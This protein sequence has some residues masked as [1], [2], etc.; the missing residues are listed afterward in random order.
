MFKGPSTFSYHLSWNKLAL[1]ENHEFAENVSLSACAFPHEGCPALASLL[2]RPCFA[3]EAPCELGIFN[4]W[5]FEVV[6][7]FQELWHD[8]H[9]LHL[10]GIL[11]VSVQGVVILVALHFWHRWVH[12]KLV[13]VFEWLPA[14]VTNIL[15]AVSK[16]VICHQF[17]RCAAWGATWFT[18]TVLTPRI[19]LALIWHT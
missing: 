13:D 16:T 11:V 1:F 8:L 3:C 9:N 19:C 12:L 6:S 17:V 5:L 7:F 2:T 4:Y 14:F 15:P 18:A 10:M